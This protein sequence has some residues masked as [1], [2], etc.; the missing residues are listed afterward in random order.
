MAEE[1]EVKTKED[2]KMKKGI[3]NLHGCMRLRLRC[4]TLM[5]LA[6]LQGNSQKQLL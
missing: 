4:H 1:S 3:D 2:A 5:R 6:E